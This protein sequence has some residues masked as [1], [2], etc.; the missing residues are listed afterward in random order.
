MLAFVRV[1]SAGNAQLYVLPLSED[2]RPTGEA[3]RLDVPQALIGSPAWT[4]DGQQIVCDAGPSWYGGTLWRV[5][6]SD[7]EKPVSLASLGTNSHQP[8][9]SRLGG[10]LT[11][12]VGSDN[13]DI[14]RAEVTGRAGPAVKLIASTRQEFNP[15]YSPDGLRVAFSSD[16]SGN[17]EIWVCNGDGSDPVQL[18]SLGSSSGTPRWFPDGKRIVFDSI[19]EKQVDIYV[20][21]TDTRVPRR[22]TSDPSDDITP[23]VSHDG[24]WIYFSS[25]RTSRWEIWRLAV[26]GGEAV[27]VTHE[28]GVRPLES[29][30]GKVIYY[31]NILGNSDVWRVPLAGGV[32]T[33]VLGLAVNAAFAVVADGIYY[34]EPGPPGYAGWIK[35]N[36]LKFFNFAKGTAE[37]VFDIKYWPQIGLSVSPDGRYVLF[38]QF[39]PFAH[40]LMLVENFR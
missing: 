27:Q 22:L 6:V 40:D 13:T 26:E 2:C 34:I 33:R 5:S 17:D 37:K 4:A 19:N 20:I 28:G 29:P 21:D 38:S 9:L 39:D 8:S 24:K 7:S 32:E 11:Y 14:W 3:R 16:R 10:R 1:I 15:Q 12:I 30:D 31:Q 25:I 23:S 35:G 36:S 18:T